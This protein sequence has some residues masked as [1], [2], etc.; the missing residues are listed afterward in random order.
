MFCSMLGAGLHR[1][2]AAG[3]P[4]DWGDLDTTH[5]RH[6]H[7]VRNLLGAVVA[8]AVLAVVVHPAMLGI[9]VCLVPFLLLELVMARRSRPTA[10]IP[11]Y[12]PT[13]RVEVELHDA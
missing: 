2:A 12:R 13:A 9:I 8:F 10:R 3:V 4:D 6:R 5:L 1:S 11:D 7:H